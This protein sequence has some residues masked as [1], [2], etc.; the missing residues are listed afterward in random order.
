MFL[1]YTAFN[2]LLYIYFNQGDISKYPNDIGAIV[3]ACSSQKDEASID[4]YNFI[5]SQL[6]KKICDV[7]YPDLIVAAL[8]LKDYLNGTTSLGDNSNTKSLFIV[9]TAFLKYFTAIA[10]YLNLVFGI[11]LKLTVPE[12][13][14]KYNCGNTIFNLDTLQPRTT[15]SLNS[16]IW[17]CKIKFSFVI[18]TIHKDVDLDYLSKMVHIYEYVL[19]GN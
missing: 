11:T 16:V 1:N 13:L 6:F 12:K 18:T 15:V 8:T 10:I 5:K 9:Y 3:A 7:S 2:H 17:F 19:G 14:A 4:F